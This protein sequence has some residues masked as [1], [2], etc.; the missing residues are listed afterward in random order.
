M[1]TIN[2][3]VTAKK[4]AP[5]KVT[6]LQQQLILGALIMTLTCLAMG[7]Y[8]DMLNTKI[9]NLTR[10]KA[11]AEARI[12]DQENMLKEVK[13]VED[14]RKLVTEKIALIEQLKK[15]QVILVHL[16]DQVSKALPQGVNVTIL[17]ERG[18]QVDLDGMAFTN[19]DIVRFVDNL[20]ACTSC[21]DV[22]LKESVQ[23]VQEGIE[24]YKYKMQFKFKGV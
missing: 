9:K 24:I 11:A 20:K 18:G 5:K 7:F 15:N 21:S 14:Q 13:S 4:K 6:E 17:S 19:H 16:L 3:L 1:I 10:D 22:F 12:R 2:L 8:W 23:S